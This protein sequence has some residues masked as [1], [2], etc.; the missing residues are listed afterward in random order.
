MH[1]LEQNKQEFYNFVTGLHNLYTVEHSLL[2]DPDDHIGVAPEGGGE[3][4]E[5]RSQL[6]Q[7]RPHLQA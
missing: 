1:F 2:L 4:G 7:Q 3:V 5:P 6:H